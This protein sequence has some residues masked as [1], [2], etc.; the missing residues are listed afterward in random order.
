M[1]G[2]ALQLSV[3]NLLDEEYRSFPGMPRIGRMALVR[4]R[5]QFGNG[6]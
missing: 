2:V 1:P 4:L 5:Y 3:Q 6:R